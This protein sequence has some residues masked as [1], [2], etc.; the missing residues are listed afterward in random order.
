[1][2]DSRE[3]KPGQPA[4]VTLEQM[5]RAR[6]ERAQHTQDLLV[7]WDCTVV[8]L[9]LNTPGPVKNNPL[10]SKAFVEGLRLARDSFGAALVRQEQIAADTGY[11]AWLGVTESP[12]EAKRRTCAIEESDPLGRIFDFDVYGP[13]GTALSRTALGGRVRRCLLCGGDAAACGRSRRHSA[14][15]LFAREEEFIADYFARGSAERIGAAATRALLCEVCVTPKPGLVDRQGSGA[16]RDMDIYTFMAS[17]SAL[18]PYFVRFARQG[19]EADGDDDAL[20]CRLREL[21]LQAERAM[22][23]ATGGV[24]THKGAIFTFALLCAAAG[25]CTGDGLLESA[26]NISREVARIASCC[27]FDA[28]RDR[29]GGRADRGVF[30]EAHSGF[31]TALRVGLPALRDALAAG[32]SEDAAGCSALLH[33]LATADD[34]RLSARAGEE[35]RQRAQDEAKRMVREGRVAPRDVRRLGEMFCRDNLSPGGSADLLAASWFL[36]FVEETADCRYETTE[37]EESTWN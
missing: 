23:A 2:S 8:C 18:A 14:S 21:G 34:S 16:H 31:A 27:S 15:E 4:G 35:A 26:Q 11:T 17:A 20:F 25:R 30:A 24:N 33:I 37:T 1:M 32:E 9:T 5:L 13:D 29:C 10:L 28:H 3:K 7:R 19:L 22:F 12:D 36:F 6:E